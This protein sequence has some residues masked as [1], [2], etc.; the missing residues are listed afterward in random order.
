MSKRILSTLKILPLHTK[1]I[2]FSV[3]F[4]G[5]SIHWKIEQKKETPHRNKND[6]ALITV[7]FS[8]ILFSTH[9]PRISSD[10]GLTFWSSH[11]VLLE[12]STLLTIKLEYDSSVRKMEMALK[13]KITSWVARIH[14]R[15][16]RFPFRFAS[17]KWL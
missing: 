1:I 5:I 6:V 11:C 10:L 4:S 8:C 12:I 14:N 13:A 15:R 3:R 7:S 16:K 9:Y 17:R 2:S